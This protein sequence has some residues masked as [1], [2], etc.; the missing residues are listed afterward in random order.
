MLRIRFTGDDLG[1]VRVACRPH[2]L[3]ETVLSL[4]VLQTRQRQGF[5]GWRDHAL[6]GLTRAP[7]QDAMR[8]LR[9]LVPAH[10]Y[11]PDFL[12]PADGDGRVSDG[13]AAVVNTPPRRVAAELELLAAQGGRPPAELA[14]GAY[15]RLDRLGEALALYH[16]TVIAPYSWPMRALIEADRAARAQALL[17]GGVEA[18]FG[19]LRPAIRW[20]PPVLEADYPVDQ[21]LR[22]N[23]R[24]LLLVPS[25]FCRR[26]PIT[27]LD[28]SLPPTLVYPIEHEGEPTVPARP[29]AD[30]P[31][32]ALIGTTRG[33]VLR[34]L[35]EVGCSTSE[36]A[37]RVGISVASASQHAAVLRRNGLVISRRAGNAVMHSRTT[38]GIAVL[39]GGEHAT[40]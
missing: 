2:A 34:R 38:L 26:H 27:L 1:R 23:G 28:S 22:L 10:G 20:R 14:A 16:S 9:P 11:F 39:R 29:D 7:L 15:T 3:W 37:R 12:T 33:E 25:V 17:D 35:D 18:L 40:G 21:D 8:I 13:I 6:A 19:T 36:L 4:H 32:G 30:D 5:A 31:L 24:G